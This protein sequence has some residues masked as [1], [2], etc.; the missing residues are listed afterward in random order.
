MSKAGAV[1]HLWAKT[2]DRFSHLGPQGEALSVLWCY[3]RTIS[4]GS[5][6]SGSG[7]V[8]VL[9]LIDVAKSFD[10]HQVLRGVTWQFRP[11]SMTL[12]QGPNGSGKTTLVKAICGSL[13]YEGKISYNGGALALKNQNIAW[14]FDDAPAYPALP[15]RE[16]LSL[17][18][19]VDPSVGLEFLD[20]EVLGRP[21]GG[22]S[23][24]QRHRLSLAGV[25][26]SSAPILV[27]D[28]PTTGLDE[29]ANDSLF[30]KLGALKTHKTII[31]VS[32]DTDRMV[33]M[34]DEIC[35]LQAGQL[36]ALAR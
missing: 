14:A 30:H 25:L 13:P 3:G 24:G 1:G 36:V 27:L 21:A 11:G 6:C 22:Y 28:E 15:G 29:Q 31:V 2:S 32:H 23:M 10:G 18:Y 12:I 35:V 16:N 33:A 34:A 7:S 5:R 9:E 4:A 26:H 17:L 8:I 19:G 20:T